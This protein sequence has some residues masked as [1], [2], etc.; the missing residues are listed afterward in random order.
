MKCEICG[1]EF[2]KLNG[3]AKH[4]SLT[5]N[6]SGKDYYDTYIKKNGEGICPV[7]GKETSFRNNWV[8]LKYC[9][10]KCAHQTLYWNYEKYNKTK[11]EFY[12]EI[13][14]KNKDKLKQISNSKTEQ[15]AKNILTTNKIK[16]IKIDNYRTYNCQCEICGSEFQ[17]DKYKIFY[18]KRNNLPLCTNCFPKNQKLE[19]DFFNFFLKNLIIQL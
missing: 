17:L 12:K 3:L 6:I 8:Y 15:T 1:N 19:E 7:C 18:N 11:S 4:L 13:A 16:L 10:Y 9:S 2:E 5:H 14:D